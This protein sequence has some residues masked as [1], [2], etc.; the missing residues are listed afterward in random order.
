LDRQTYLKLI[1]PAITM[2]IKKGQDYNSGPTLEEYFPFGELSYTQMVYMKAMRLRSLMQVPKPN[3]EGKKDTVLDLI[4]YCVFYLDYL[5]K[6]EK[7]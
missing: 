6:Q 2:V 3:F 5:D 1:D 4:N 7:I